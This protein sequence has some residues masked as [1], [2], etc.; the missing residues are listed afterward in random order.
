MKTK[1]WTDPIVDEIHDIRKKMAEES[2]YDLDK[3]VA[4]LQESQ[5]LRGDRVVT[6][7][8]RKLK[9]P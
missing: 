2:D 1:Q 4:R 3:F 8:P 6:R 9:K 7:P 5:K